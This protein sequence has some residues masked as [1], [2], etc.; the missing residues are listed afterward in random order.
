MVKFVAYRLKERASV[1]WYR[2]REMRMRKECGLVQKWRRMKQLLRGRLFPPDY[3][4]CVFYA[5][6]G[7]IHGKLIYY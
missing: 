6:Y 5:Y 1:W 3:E 4:Q 7:C 2:L